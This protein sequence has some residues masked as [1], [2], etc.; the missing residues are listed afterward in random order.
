M[1]E[2]IQILTFS[3]PFEAHPVEAYLEANGIEVFLRDE[4]TIQ[5]KPMLSNAVGGVKL[6]IS[7]DDLEKAIALLK[8][9]GYA[10]K[11]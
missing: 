5:A 2:M 11:K 6:F 3:Q 7:S 1:P 8:E 10:I 9:A 4:Y